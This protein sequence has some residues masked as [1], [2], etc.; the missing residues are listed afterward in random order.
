MDI[1]DKVNKS[2]YGSL[3]NMTPHEAY[4]IKIHVCTMTIVS[5]LPYTSI[6]VFLLN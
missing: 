4:S 6:E 3:L 2:P 1:L 5:I